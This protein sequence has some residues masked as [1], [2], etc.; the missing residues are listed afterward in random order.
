MNNFQCNIMLIW[1]QIGGAPLSEKHIISKINEW[2]VKERQRLH[3]NKTKVNKEYLRLFFSSHCLE[4]SNH[5][6]G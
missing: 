2:F 4:R 5:R 6:K 3:G 1:L